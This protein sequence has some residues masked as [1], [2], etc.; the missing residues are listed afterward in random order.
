[1][2]KLKTFTGMK[3]IAIISAAMFLVFAALSCQKENSGDKTQNTVLRAVIA[4]GVKTAL[5]EK[6]GTG[7]PNY[8]KKDDAISVNGVESEPLGF[9]YDG[10]ASANF[11]FSTTPGTPYYAAY[12][13][14]AVSEYN[15]GTAVV[16]VPATQE[17]VEGSYDPAAFIMAGKSTEEGSVSMSAKVSIFHLSITGDASVSGV[18]L[19]GE[20]GAVL[21]GTFTTDFSG[22]TARESSNVVALNCEEPVELPAD[23]FIC[24][25]AGL[26]GKVQVEVFDNEGGSMIRTANIKE[27]LTA[28]Q[29]YLAPE[30][31]YTPTSALSASLKGVTTSSAAFTWTHSGDKDY[32]ISKPYTIALY[33]DLG[34]NSKVI[35]LDIPEEASCW[36]GK[37]PCFVFGGLESGKTYYFRATDTEDGIVSNVVAATTGEFTNVAYD[38]LENSAK[39]GDVILAENF[40]EWGYGTDETMG[41]AGFLDSNKELTKFSGDVDMEK[42][43]LAVP[44][45]TERRLFNQTTVRDSDTRIE[46]WG[47]A[48]NSSVYLR[49]GYLRVTTTSTGNRTHI[50][51]PKLAAIPEGKLATV[52]VTARMLRTESDNEFGV[53]VQTGTMNENYTT[54][55]GAP[56]S[57]KLQSGFTDSDAYPFPMTTKGSWETHTVTIQNLTNANSLAFGSISN[58]DKKNRFYIAE[59]SVKLTALYDP[60]PLSA[61][62]SDKTSSTLAFK[63]TEGGEASE[64]IANAYTATL[65]KDESCTQ[66]DQSFDIPAGNGCWNGKQPCFIFGGLKP[67]TSYWFKVN[68]TTNGIESNSVRVT[69]DAFTVVTMPSEITKTGVVLAEDFG[70][71]RWDFDNCFGASGFFPSSTSDFSNTVVSTYRKNGDSGEKT[72]KGQS[73]ALVKSRL[74]DWVTDSNV[75]VHPGSLKLGTSSGRG[76]ILTP[77]FKVPEG[78][79]AV[80]NVTVTAARHNSS[81]DQD[82]AIVVLS[83]DLAKAD[84]SKHTADFGWP[85]TDDATFYQTINITNSSVWNTRT[86]SGLEI[87]GGDRI[88]F[89]GKNGGSGSKGRVWIS[90]I[91]VEVTAIQDEGENL[92]KLSIIGDSISSFEGWLPSGNKHFADYNIGGGLQD[93]TKTYWGALC[94]TYMKGLITIEK[95]I[96]WTGSCVA[97]DTREGSDY[98]PAFVTR[99]GKSNVGTTYALNSIGSPDI[100]IIY[101]GTNDRYNESSGLSDVSTTPTDQ[102]FASI[103]AKT[104][105]ALSVTS[106][107]EAY[108]KLINMVHADCPNAKIINLIGDYV[109][110]AQIASIKK[111]SDHFDFCHYIDFSNGGSPNSNIGKLNGVHPNIAGMDY[112]AKKIY[113]EQGAWMVE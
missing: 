111:I 99:Y 54:G 102:E 63:W 82:W 64:D 104:D 90:D 38:E 105:D 100:V 84:P 45:S 39:V 32:D 35:S 43:T 81:Q 91:T 76:W 15:A 29:M 61:K 57:C 107:V 18:R 89:G 101:G 113:D 78:K 109:T 67:S 49:A 44:G 1:M 25:P 27:A 41:A 4:D 72:F 56:V 3:K 40:N 88:A 22:L 48:G 69:T 66:V 24:V 70:E 17:Y 80:V 58:V 85:D 68:D 9:T 31:G 37:Q 92:K 34:C 28:G 51:T 30:L 55:S 98:R 23:F 42:V 77:E 21:S 2:G 59:I 93:W 11:T 50:V 19:T 16:T 33:T 13:A 6:D 74:N 52:E 86:V 97:Q 36:D 8:W 112:M 26:S 60:S 83:S 87:R 75:Y 47:F 62:C 5:G 108:V 73:T 7:W 20:S 95:N 10:E 103:F 14:S 94:N 46:W 12:P 106:F 110:T 53:L 71:L 96:S 79:K 65:Y